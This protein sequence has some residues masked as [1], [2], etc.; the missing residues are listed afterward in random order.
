MYLL[1]GM[2]ISNQSIKRYFDQNN[3]NYSVYVDQKGVSFPSLDKVSLVVKSP[4]IK[5]DTPFLVYCKEFKVQIVSDIELFYLLNRPKYIIAVSGSNGKTTVTS[6]LGKLLEEEGFL[7]VGNIGI[8]V[9]DYINKEEGKF[10]VECSSYMLEYTSMFKPNIYVL[11][12]IEKH[13]LDHHHTFSNYIKAKLK[14]LKNMTS[15]DF[16]VYS[17]DDVLLNRLLSGYS[18]K[19]ITNS[20][21]DSLMVN[22]DKLKI[23]GK[24]N[25][26]NIHTVLK[27]IE[28][29][30]I[31]IN[32]KIDK[33]Y[34]I[35][36][37]PH[38]L[39]KFFVPTY[40]L[41]LFIN[42]SKSTNVHSLKV[43]LLDVLSKYQGKNIY[44]II[45]GMKIKQDY[46]LVQNL[47]L[48]LNNV[49]CF[50]EAG[51]CY[52]EYTSKLNKPYETLHTLL[53]DFVKIN[54]NKEDVVLFSP[55]APS[56][57]EFTSFEVRGTYFKEFL[58]NIKDK[59]FD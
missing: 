16:V 13:H 41:T 6:I 17:R 31:N 44:L 46:H 26:K 51:R 40:P 29:L 48:N 35:E 38:R 37:L 18:S 23:S 45:G 36:P 30:N 32:N 27:V 2:G 59:S 28:I 56:M 58:C 12:N 7:T 21:N 10:I 42:D 5:N 9:F 3:I 11:L 54:F 55:G 4:G 39:E 25:L 43:A 52:F 47:L 15:N 33:I 57:D 19:K 14:P 34:G 24:H 8:P 53:N 22:I 1:Y 50:G 20:I 49:F